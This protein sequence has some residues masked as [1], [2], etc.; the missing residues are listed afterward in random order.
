MVRWRKILDDTVR[1]GRKYHAKSVSLAKVQ[2]GT[3]YDSQVASMSR[4][5]LLAKVLQEG[6]ES[7]EV[8]ITREQRHYHNSNDAT[9][10]A[11]F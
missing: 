10:C 8:G 6:G 2:P 4:Q 1:M 5:D 9:L 7:S 3:L 11:T